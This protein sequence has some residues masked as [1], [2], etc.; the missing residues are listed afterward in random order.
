M[1]APTWALLADFGIAKLLNDSQH[2]TMTGFI[3]GTAAYM[4]PEQASGKVIDART[5]LYAL[6]VVLYEM[7]TGR[8]PFDAD[9]PMA[10][11]TKHVY[12]P[13]PP[14][15]TL[16]RELS[17]V[18]EAV[19]LRALAKDPNQ[20]Y[21][22]AAEMAA[23][24]ERVATHLGRPRPSSQVTSLYQ[25][26][27]EAFEQGR[28]DEAAERLG[29]LVALAPDYEDATVLLNAAKA[30]QARAAQVA[31]GSPSAHVAPIGYPPQVDSAP[32]PAIEATLKVAPITG[33][34]SDSSN[35]GLA[36]ITGADTVPTSK[37]GLCLKCGQSLRPEWQV[38]PYC[39][40]AILP[41]ATEP[42][43]S[44]GTLTQPFQAGATQPGRRSWRL[45]AIVGTVLVLFGGAGGGYAFTRTNNAG[46]IA[47]IVVN[48]ATASPT[49]SASPTDEPTSTP[50][51]T[52]TPTD[53]ATPTPS[54]TPTPTDTATPTPSPTPTAT[55]APTPK[56]TARPKPTPKPAVRVVPTEP[57][58]PV[59]P[60]P[61]PP[62]PVPPT[63]EPP[64]QPPSQPTSDNNNNPK[65]RPKP[66]RT[67][68][69]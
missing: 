66:T 49:T 48:T 56:P 36:P 24:L 20:R 38:C 55:N 14:P 58:T 26:G 8:V 47:P 10:V 23:D 41:P 29:R 59:P 35:A 9:T 15:R 7:L 33:R 43:Q 45:W 2:L 65:P 57:P 19:L 16:N 11:L 34:L 12:E 3:I 27:V 69:P 61:E 54:P 4:A 40:T 42:G 44:G 1:P 64:T 28:W 17:P 6:G 68:R 13:P 39:R 18:V 60:T 46:V 32:T 50:S 53:T 31:A 52:P 21:Q 5:D 51:P 30:E 25:S 37:P 63:P 62:T 67:P 22:S